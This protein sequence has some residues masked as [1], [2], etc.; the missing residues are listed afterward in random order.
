MS[1]CDSDASE[2]SV[3]PLSVEQES[4]C[5]D[6]E[7]ARPFVECETEGQNFIAP[8]LF[9]QRPAPSQRWKQCAGISIGL[10]VITTAVCFGRKRVQEKRNP[11]ITAPVVGIIEQPAS[12][13]NTPISKA[14]AIWDDQFPCYYR[15]KHN[16]FKEGMFYVKV[17]KTASSTLAGVGLRIAHRKGSQLLRRDEHDGEV[18]VCNAHTSHGDVIADFHYAR[19]DRVR[20]FLWTFLREPTRRTVSQYFFNQVSRHGKEPTDKNIIKWARTGRTSS[21][22][23]Q[24]DYSRLRDYDSHEESVRGILD[25]YDFIGI[26][27]RLDESLV[28]LQIILGLDIGDTLYLSAKAKQGAYV[29]VRGSG[30]SRCIQEEKSFVSP[31][32]KTYFATNEWQDHVAGDTLLYNAANRSLDRTI[33][34]IGREKVA[35]RLQMFRDALGAATKMCKGK[36]IFPC[37]EDG[38]LQEEEKNCYEMDEGCG[39]PCLDA[40]ADNITGSRI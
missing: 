6:S 13:D 14:F 5:A 36:A 19:R 4:S 8:A 35:A 1:V 9:R 38:S 10:L 2:T 40:F 26:T 33:D 20:S 31:G 28:V 30:G 34:Q 18:Q 23:F 25:D 11:P 15:T 17:P 3:K 21:G 39:F 16:K 37:S 32:M 27:E 24:L 12:V 7:E 29:Y 22:T